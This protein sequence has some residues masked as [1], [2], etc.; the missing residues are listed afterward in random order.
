MW[1]KPNYLSINGLTQLLITFHDY[2]LYKISSGV[3]EKPFKNLQ[4]SETH[5]KGCLH[6]LLG[7]QC[8]PEENF[9]HFEASSS[10]VIFK[11]SIENC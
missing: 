5:F 11:N 2:I 1:N 3:M 4:I 6:L 9:V 7:C 8:N 10:Y